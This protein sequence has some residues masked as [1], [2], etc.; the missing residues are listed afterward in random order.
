MLTRTSVSG[1]LLG[2]GLLLAQASQAQAAES[3][4]RPQ[5]RYRYVSLVET[6]PEEFLGFDPAGIA[7]DGSV[8]GTTF[9][10]DDVECVNLVAC[11]SKGRWVT[12]G[13]GFSSSINDKGIVGGAVVDEAGFPHAALF[14][15]GRRPV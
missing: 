4:R 12:L 14:E 11:Y 10:C 1:V 7:N 2:V 8:C 5:L 13:E 6:L 3:E 15:R 9:T